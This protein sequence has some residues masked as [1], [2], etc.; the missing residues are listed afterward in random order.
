MATK[1]D[2]TEARVEGTYER[3]PGSTGSGPARSLGRGWASSTLGVVASP[4]DAGQQAYGTPDDPAV[5]RG[6]LVDW[7]LRMSDLPPIRTLAR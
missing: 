3:W 5:P 7:V 1:S 2:F 6:G 4:G